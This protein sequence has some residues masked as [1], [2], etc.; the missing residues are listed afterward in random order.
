VLDRETFEQIMDEYC[1]QRGWDPKTGIPARKA[2]TDLGLEDAI[3]GH[4]RGCLNSMLYIAF[5][6]YVSIDPEGGG[7]R[8]FHGDI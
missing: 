2:L 3:G 8:I 5:S 4:S 1:D 6:C 7:K